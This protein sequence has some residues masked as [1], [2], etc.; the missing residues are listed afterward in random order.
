MPTPTTEELIAAVAAIPTSGRWEH[1]DY[2]AALR[3]HAAFRGLGYNERWNIIRAAILQKK[4]DAMQT[5]QVAKRMSAARPK[6][7]A[8]KAGVFKSRR[9]KLYPDYCIDENGHVV[10]P[11]GT[12]LKYR[13]DGGTPYVRVS[14][15]DRKV[16][17]LLVEAGFQE[18]PADKKARRAK[19]ETGGYN[20]AAEAR[21][22]DPEAFGVDADGNS[23]E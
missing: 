18:S 9:L 13:W 19:A 12:E 3:D 6:S 4:Q 20:D 23:L 14:G 21:A 15:K 10:G 7:L 22:E 11:T 2:E 1:L 17:W 5:R 8:K 16:Y